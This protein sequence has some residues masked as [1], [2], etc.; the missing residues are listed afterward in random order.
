[1]QQRGECHGVA[2]RTA[3]SS[4]LVLAPGDGEGGCRHPVGLWEQIF[5][6]WGCPWS[7]LWKSPQR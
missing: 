3:W 1:M 2:A 5:K 4:A 7:A 6:I